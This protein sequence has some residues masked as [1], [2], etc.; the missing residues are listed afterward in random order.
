MTDNKTEQTTDFPRKIHA[1]KKI[2]H[3]DKKIKTLDK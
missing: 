1:R 3:V 2:K